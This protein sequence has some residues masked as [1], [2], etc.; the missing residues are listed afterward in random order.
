M[1]IILTIQIVK[2]CPKNQSAHKKVRCK[3]IF[4]GLEKNDKKLKEAGP[5]VLILHYASLEIKSLEQK[6]KGYKIST[7]QVC[8]TYY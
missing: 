7:S 1:T 8:L 5:H 2:K 4:D 3:Q 6:V